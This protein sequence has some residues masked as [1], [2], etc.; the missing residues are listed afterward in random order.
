MQDVIKTKLAVFAVFEPLLAG[1]VP[2]NIKLTGYRRSIIKI[3]GFIDKPFFFP[4]FGPI[5]R[6]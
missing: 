6:L 5:F 2:A 3:L 4:G 1:L